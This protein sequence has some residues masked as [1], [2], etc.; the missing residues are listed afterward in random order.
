MN[1]DSSSAVVASRIAAV[2][3]RIEGLIQSIEGLIQSM[4]QG[5][6]CRPTVSCSSRYRLSPATVQ[7]A[8]ADLSRR[9][10]W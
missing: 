7:R 5:A 1:D 8:L 9:G 10:W 6:A 4:R 2:A 3:S